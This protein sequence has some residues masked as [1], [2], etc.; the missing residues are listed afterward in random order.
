[1][2]AFIFIDESGDPG[3]LAPDGSNSK[4]YAEL[5]LQVGSD[6][7]ISLSEHVI[8]WKYVKRFSKESKTLPKGLEKFRFLEPIAILQESGVIRCSCVYIDKL[9]YI[10]GK[11]DLMD[12]KV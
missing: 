6:G 9:T 1:M 3:P 4:H 2:S 11:M 12:T 10:W 8:N 7:L 5:A